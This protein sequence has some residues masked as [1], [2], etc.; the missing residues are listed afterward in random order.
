MCCVPY[1]IFYGQVCNTSLCQVC[2]I[3]ALHQPVVHTFP[4]KGV[5]CAVAVLGSRHTCYICTF[6]DKCGFDAYPSTMRLFF[7]VIL[8]SESCA[9]HLCLFFMFTISHE[10][11]V[12][13]L[14]IVSI[15]RIHFSYSMLLYLEICACISIF[16]L[17][18]GVLR[19]VTIC[20][21]PRTTLAP[22]ERCANCDILLIV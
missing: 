21:S 20:T 8:L 3:K 13:H 18:W 14:F 19:L 11:C 6:I 5:N 4:I 1:P 22:C 9:C 12:V 2:G 16:L 7:L 17:R 10:P 15:F